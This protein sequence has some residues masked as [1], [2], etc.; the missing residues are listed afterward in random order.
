MNV[1]APTQKRRRQNDDA[2]LPNFEA[3]SDAQE[4]PAEEQANLPN[5][6]GQAILNQCW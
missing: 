1:S 6:R 5:P 2:H 4:A 3:A